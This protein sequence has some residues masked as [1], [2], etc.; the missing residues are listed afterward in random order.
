MMPQ[1]NHV[2]LLRKEEMIPFVHI[3]FTMADTSFFV[4]LFP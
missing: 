3:C 4:L 2:G 1:G